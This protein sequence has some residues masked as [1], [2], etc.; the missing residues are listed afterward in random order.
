M[1][2]AGRRRGGKQDAGGE[3][4]ACKPSDERDA[5]RLE[6]DDPVDARTAVALRPI[7]PADSLP[8]ARERAA[9]LHDA[10]LS[11]AANPPS[12]PVSRGVT[13]RK[14]RLSKCSGGTA[15]VGSGVSSGCR[16][17]K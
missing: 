3:Q 16:S 9:E 8:P 11:R 13:K 5:C 17:K 15:P 12:E 10:F 6:E 14:P 7:E 1:Q 4:V 2:V